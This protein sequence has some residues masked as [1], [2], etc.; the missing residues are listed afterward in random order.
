MRKSLFVIATIYVVLYFASILPAFIYS[1][2]FF[3]H[4]Y[5]ATEKEKTIIKDVYDN[6]RTPTTISLWSLL[7]VYGLFA[8]SMFC[9]RKKKSNNA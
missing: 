4:K 5:S 9:D 1:Q 2:S 7:G 8:A 3:V 6:M